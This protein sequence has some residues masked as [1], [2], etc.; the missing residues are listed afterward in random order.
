MVTYVTIHGYIPL[1]GTSRVRRKIL[2][3]FF[4]R[5]GL[6]VHVRE[7]GRQLEVSPAVVGRELARL[8]AAGVL[9]S[10]PVGR[11]LRYSVDEA[12]PVAREVR[13]L[14]QKTVG[15]E[16][17]LASALR[18]VPGIEEAFIFGSYARSEEGPNSDLDVFIIGQPDREILSERLAEVEEELG[19]EINTVRMTRDALRREQGQGSGFIEGVL[20]GRRLPLELKH[21]RAE[22]SGR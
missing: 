7:L 15:V 13:S 17:V 12:S 22:G 6:A 21:D 2:S 11:S 4:S 10:E 20:S 3:Q 18:D 1:F 9:R 5:P 8:Q 19:R 14:F 16:A